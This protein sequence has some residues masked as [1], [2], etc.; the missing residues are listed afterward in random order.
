[1]YRVHWILFLLRNFI[2]FPSLTFSVG[3]AVYTESLF[4]S[5]GAK[6]ESFLD[7]QFWLYLYGM[8]VASV[9]H[10][11]SNPTY[12]PADLAESFVQ[13]PTMVLALLCFAMF[14][15]S[16]GGL[17][18]AA[19]LKFLDN[20]VKE[21]TGNI[22]NIIT[23]VFCSFLFP[24]KFQVRLTNPVLSRNICPTGFFPSPVSVHCVHRAQPGLPPLRHLPLRDGEGK[25]DDGLSIECLLRGKRK[26]MI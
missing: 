24:D 26:N 18:V 10:L 2:L 21:Y 22:A 25:A 9:V 4:K 6:G 8:G 19:I 1:M 7:Q 20:I 3:A 23:A 12:G 14:I 13:M 17:V 15:G 5:G 16:C 11:A